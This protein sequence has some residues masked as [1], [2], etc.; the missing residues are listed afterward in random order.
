MRPRKN[1]KVYN[2]GVPVQWMMGDARSYKEIRKELEAQYPS[3]EG[4]E[5]VIRPCTEKWQEMIINS[6]IL[7]SERFNNKFKEK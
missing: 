7:Y 4:Y 6:E 5:I 2:E 1:W 3:F